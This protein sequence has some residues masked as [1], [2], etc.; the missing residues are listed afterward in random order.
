MDAVGVWITPPSKTTEEELDELTGN[1]R[2]YCGEIDLKILGKREELMATPE[3]GTA[4]TPEMKTTL[5]SKVDELE[6][7]R[8]LLKVPHRTLHGFLDLIITNVLRVLYTILSFFLWIATCFG[9][10][11]KSS[12]SSNAF[13]LD[14]FDEFYSE[15]LTWGANAVSI[16]S[17]IVVLLSLLSGNPSTSRVIVITFSA[18]LGALTLLNR[19]YLRGKALELSF[20]K[21]SKSLLIVQIGVFELRKAQLISQPLPK[22][23]NAIINGYINSVEKSLKFAVAQI[24][25]Y[26]Y[27]APLN[28]VLFL[29]G[30]HVS[31]FDSLSSYDRRLGKSVETMGFL[32]N[33]FM[34]AQ[35]LATIVPTSMVE[36][37]RGDVAVNRGN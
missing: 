2:D 36:D 12:D 5:M 24:K 37:I 25:H 8:F 32:R 16:A 10:I 20:I 22:G 13:D 17:G 9:R 29:G 27:L 11:S 30:R 34:D 21:Y 4:L 6:H 26:A 28:R 23:Q 3:V 14:A 35:I 15:L 31:D 18:T 33:R 7:R 1:I 19:M